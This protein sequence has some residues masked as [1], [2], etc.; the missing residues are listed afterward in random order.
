MGRTQPIPLCRT[1]IIIIIF[2]K[3]L[4][5]RHKTNSFAITKSND[6]TSSPIN[7]S[8]TKTIL[9]LLLNLLLIKIS[10]DINCFFL[11]SGR[12]TPLPPARPEYL[13]T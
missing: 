11:L 10:F 3:I 5:L 7:L 13:I 8:S 12:K 1:F 2:F 9:F 4:S 6:D